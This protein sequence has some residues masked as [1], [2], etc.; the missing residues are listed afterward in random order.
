M[1]KRIVNLIIVFFIISMGFTLL[2]PPVKADNVSGDITVNTTWS[3]DKT[4]IGDVTV[5]P[6]ITLTINPGITVEFDNGMN[7]YVEGTLN[8]IGTAGSKITFTSSTGTTPGLWDSIHFKAFSTGTIQYCIIEYA[9]TGI[10]CFMASPTIRDNTVSDN[11]I[12]GIECRNYSSPDIINN[13]ITDNGDSGIYLFNHSTALVKDNDLL[14]SVVS[15]GI[16]IASSNAIVEHNYIKNNNFAGIYCELLYN[17]GYCNTTIN[18]NTV[19]QNSGEGMYFLSASPRLY[20]NVVTYN[21]GH[22]IAPAQNCYARINDNTIQHND[23]NGIDCIA[24]LAFGRPRITNNNISFN[25][26]NGIHV[27]SGSNP[28]ISNNEIRS[29]NETGIKI[30]AASPRINTNNEITYNKNHGISCNYSS[31]ARITGNNII[32]G[33]DWHGIYVNYSSPRIE[34][35][36]ITNNDWSGVH[37]QESANVRMVGNTINNNVKNGITSVTNSKSQIEGSTISNNGGFGIICRASSL[38][39]TN[40]DVNNNGNDGINLFSNS[41][42]IINDTSINSNT[43]DGIYCKSTSPIIELCD[44]LNNQVHAINTDFYSRPLVINSTITTTS[45]LDY[46]VTDNSHPISL[47]T[48]FTKNNVN[49]D[50]TSSL[51][52]QWLLNLKITNSSAGLIPGAKA[53]LIN[54]NSIEILN[55][56]TN[57][58]GT[59]KWVVGTEYEEFATTKT[60]YTPHDLSIVTDGYQPYQTPVTMDQFKWLKIVLNH[61]PTKPSNLEPVTTHNLTPALKW[62]PSIEED[63]DTVT[64]HLSLFDGVDN[65]STKLIDNAVLATTSYQIAAPLS[66]EYGK[67]YLVEL[68]ADD[69]KGGVSPTLA[70]IMYVINNRPPAPTLE[71]VPSDPKTNDN[72]RCNI[73]QASNDPDS[74]PVDT[75]YYTFKWYKND[76]LQSEYTKENSTATFIELPHSATTKH[77]LWKCEVT[78]WDGIEQGITA[79]ILTVIQNSAP[80]VTEPIADFAI[81]EDHIDATT[82]NLY[83]VFE[84]AD[85]ETIMLRAE[86]IVQDGGY[87]IKV[88]I[89]QATGKV[90]LKPNPNWHGKEVIIFYATDNDNAV[91]YEGVEIIVNS[92]NDPPILN[93]TANQTVYEYQWIYIN[94]SAHDY[95]DPRD[96]LEFSNDARDILPGL[97]KNKNYFFDKD[98]GELSISTDTDMIGSYIITVGVTDDNPNGSVS[99]QVELTVLNRN[100]PPSTMIT[101]PTSGTKLNTTTPLDFSAQATDPDLDIAGANEQLSYVWKSNLS[102]ILGYG[103]SLNGVLFKKGLHKISFIV[104]DSEGLQAKSEIEI[105]VVQITGPSNGPGIVNGNGPGPDDNGEGSTDG[106]K[107]EETDM[108]FIY[109]LIIV[110]IVLTLILTLFILKY[111]KKRKEIASAEAEPSARAE[112]PS[113]PEPA[114]VGAGPSRPQQLEKVEEPPAPPPPLPPAEAASAPTTEPVPPPQP[115]LTAQPI[116]SADTSELP[117]AAPITEP[118]TPVETTAAE[119]PEEGANLDG[120]EPNDN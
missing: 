109:I 66:L 75:I 55:S 74:D 61:V 57:Q 47:N 42:T 12:Y 63:Q 89:D 38:D 20:N 36:K 35:S 18:N 53:K 46:K 48:N 13:V 67:G 77:E 17:V 84:D 76:V 117:T 22:G 73:T 94:L 56:S 41:I 64:Y 85:N 65:A 68:Y 92:I 45:G 31:R 6:G 5:K 51:M 108:M 19:T 69:G 100:D 8:A 114:E 88:D 90:T 83:D 93:H 99:Q 32:S 44:I 104:T 112:P 95:A 23:K 34:N 82:I 25:N 102:G 29:N 26:W 70:Q 60:M 15:Y 120:G 113:K 1:Y 10:Y 71:L 103:L 119:P 3:I 2:N 105:K 78:P 62:S 54:L 118:A 49:I 21:G 24:V 7:L 80:E 111:N 43:G 37:L 81:D 11:S 27:Y 87:N 39:I 16:H 110:I 79:K 40:S 86:R 33:N 96:D 97:R 59:I 58:N 14:N 115:P 72:L 116:S 101:T 4:V 50:S 52:V 98:T 28:T 9:T 91:A 107:G 30:I 106:D